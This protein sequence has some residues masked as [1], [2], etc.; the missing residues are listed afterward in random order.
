M[1]N[2]PTRLWIA[3]LLLGW[4]FDILFWKKSAGI[5]FALFTTL[6]LLGGFYVL[7][8]SGLRPAP[9]S[10]WLLAPFGF[11]AAIAFIRQEPLTIFLAYTF[12]FFSM[13]LLAATYIGGRWLRYGLL[14]YFNKFSR[15]VGSMITRAGDFF[16]QVR[17]EQAE[18]GAA[19][20][21]PFVWAVIRGLIVAF[22]IV[23]CFAS[24][25][26]S[27]DAIFN[28]KLAEFFG[29]FNLGRISEY[30]LRLALIFSC[31]YLLAGAFLH[32]ATQSKDEKLIG[33]DKPVIKP[34]LG[35][36][37]S[38]TILGSVAIL[39]LV[40][41]VIQFRYFFGGEVNIGIEGYTYSEYARRGF[42]E[43]VL[44]AFFSLLMILGLS[45]VTKREVEF[46]RR[47]YSG[48]SIAV[49]TLVMVILLSAYQRLS[50]DILAH[51]LS[52]L[53]LYPRIF[54]IWVGL[55]LVTVV[56]LETLHRERNFAI[57]TVLAS[58]GFAVSLTLVNVDASIVKHN[59]LRASQGRYLNVSYLASLS[60]DAVPTLAE[61]YLSPSI[62]LSVREG[63]GASLL[64]HLYSDS[65]TGDQSEDW[66]SINLS[67]WRAKKA[68]EGVQAQ[69]QAYK[70]NET[71]VTVKVRTPSNVLYLC[72]DQNDQSND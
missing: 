2:H 66:R 48:L 56:V 62:P 45:T 11:F 30:L 52:R 40:F 35:F 38:A 55:L 24:L 26:A 65:M 23:A 1:I 10:L 16:T 44:V 36:T 42:N 69:L 53:R 15:L 3:T 54:L 61:A 33:E 31:A 60:T 27:A 37:E 59:V 67:R 21:S 39:F 6:C 29:L 49:V 34:F 63:I 18:R 19:R 58:L 47:V 71:R 25:L 68:L 32:A 70:V 9:K 12:V 5:N 14:D 13:G 57:A 41:V 50:L 7:L 43:L 46:Q 51:G 20:I 17:K 28:Q 22:P 4:T 72:Q 64:C 8:D